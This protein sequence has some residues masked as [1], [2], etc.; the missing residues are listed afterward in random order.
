MGFK[1]CLLGDSLFSEILATSLES[2]HIINSDAGCFR[3]TITVQKP[4]ESFTS[5]ILSSSRGYQLS[6]LLSIPAVS[7][8]DSGSYRCFALNEKGGSATELRLDVRGECGCYSFAHVWVVLLTTTTLQFKY[9][10]ESLLY[11]NTWMKLLY[12]SAKGSNQ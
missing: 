10:Q 6:A 5:H 4:D 2:V 3:L 9:L 8:S 7:R 11:K 12:V 1:I